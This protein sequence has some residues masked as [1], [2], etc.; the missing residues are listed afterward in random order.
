[1]LA[2][3]LFF[4]QS[5]SM[6]ERGRQPDTYFLDNE[7]L[8]LYVFSLAHNHIYTAPNHMRTAYEF[9]PDKASASLSVED[10][11][12][13]E[14]AARI[15]RQLDI[16]FQTKQQSQKVEQLMND[17]PLCTKEEILAAMQHFRP[18]SPEKVTYH[19]VDYPN[20]LILTTIALYDENETPY[21]KRVIIHK[22]DE[23]V[24]E[25]YMVTFVDELPVD[26][27]KSIGSVNDEMGEET[28]ALRDARSFF[29]QHGFDSRPAYLELQR[30]ATYLKNFP[31]LW[32]G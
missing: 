25:R 20:E 18:K 29:E 8:L 1:M 15:S 14:T 5:N 16:F 9:V 30:L 4:M 26:I 10:G 24:A 11:D 31:D 21:A 12:D 3:L 13:I 27:K 7:G 2:S 6:H 17:N 19:A 23:L 28:E 32:H 22:Q